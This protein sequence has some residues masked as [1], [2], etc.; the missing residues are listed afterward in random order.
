MSKSRL[1]LKAIEH[2]LR[3][4]QLRFPQINA[5]LRSRRDSMTDEVIENMMAGYA[6]INWAIADD[7]DLLD[8]R[9]VA[10]LLELNHVVLCG[11]DPATR[12]EHQK[13][14]QATTQRFYAQDE[15]NINNILR[16]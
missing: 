7:T 16:W 8:S 14:T 13:H 6:F 12:R 9:Y 4:V 5:M 15:F 2:S 3:D 11:R 10:G 1:N